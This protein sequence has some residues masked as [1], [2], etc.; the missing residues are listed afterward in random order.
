MILNI[1]WDMRNLKQELYSIDDLPTPNQHTDCIFSP[2]GRYIVTG[3]S[4]KKGEEG[5]LLFLDSKDLKEFKR[6]PLLNSNI[7]RII[8]HPKINQILVGNS[9]DVTVLYSNSSS[10]N[11]A[12]LCASKVGRKKAIEDDVSFTGPIITPHSLPLFQEK[13]NRSQKRKREKQRQ[14]AAASHKPGFFFFLPSSFFLFPFSFFLLPSSFLFD[15]FHLFSLHSFRIT[16]DW[17]IK[18][19]SC[20]FQPLHSP[21]YEDSD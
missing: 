4:N 1:V 18:R 10:I 5:A 19:W 6:L 20:F 3:T 21:H 15:F 13:S 8:W 7:S 16:F 17:S 2:D 12:K 14:D 11:G 9:N